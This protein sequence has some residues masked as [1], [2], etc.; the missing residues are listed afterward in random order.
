MIVEYKFCSTTLYIVV[1]GLGPAGCGHAQVAPSSASQVALQV[2]PLG[3]SG[4]VL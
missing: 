2:A 1:L 4:L 3:A